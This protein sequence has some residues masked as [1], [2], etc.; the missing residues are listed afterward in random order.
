MMKLLLN[1]WMFLMESFISIIGRII[2]AVK[3]GLPVDIL[4]GYTT[5]QQTDQKAS[6]RKVCFEKWMFV[7]FS[8]EFTNTLGV[9][10]LS[11]LYFFQ[12]RK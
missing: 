2:E 12:G 11:Q 3:I 10:I 9:D 1:S 6:N 8:N 7:S 5:K 4:H